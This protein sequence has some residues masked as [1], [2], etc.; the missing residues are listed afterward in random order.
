MRASLFLASIVTLSA[1]GCGDD[2]TSGSGGVG[3][4]SSGGSGGT[5]TTGGSGGVAS[6][7]DI[8]CADTEFCHAG[9]CRA[10]DAPTGTLHDRTLELGDDV[11][12]RHYFLHVPAGYACGKGTALL[13]DFHGTATGNRA[14][15]AYQLDALI[16]LSEAHDVIV[17][18]P[19]S[20]SSMEGGVETFRWDQ[21]PGDLERNVVFT[22]RLV[23]DL[24][25]RYD[26]DPL[27]IYATGFSSG[28]NM[29]S[30]FLATD[31]RGL[32]SGLA[33]IAGGIWADVN[34]EP[35]DAGEAPRFY[36]ATGFRDYLHASK[37]VLEEKLA[38]LGVPAEKVFVPGYDTGHDLYAWH[39]EELWAFLDTGTRP[40]AGSVTAP[41]QEEVL[42]DGV[43]I[44]EATRLPDGRI[45]A[46]G[47]RGDVLVRSV[48]GVWSKLTALS[49]AAPGPITGI[50]AD[51]TGAI[52]AVGEQAF[53]ASDAALTFGA[54]TTV[55]EFFGQFFG[56]AYLN[57][58]GCDASGAVV[59]AGYWSGAKS[60]DAGATWG[61][62][63]ADNLG[64]PGQLSAM[65]VTSQGTAIGVG[66]YDYIGRGAVTGTAL[67]YVDH[68]ATSEW[69]NGIGSSGNDVWVVGDG[70]HIVHSTDDGASFLEESSGSSA[71]LYAV[72]AADALMA[73]AVGREGTVVYT[74]DGGATWKSLSTGT[75]GYLGAVV[76]EDANT[77]LGLG[78]RALRATLPLN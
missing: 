14:E 69:W 45:A 12:D 46:T 27:R 50:C 74:R 48:A 5:I 61:G 66:Y 9:S 6:C 67:A 29:T 21:N 20:R 24:R 58:V 71:D 34:A 78:A 1:L 38:E 51:A 62:F 4:S 53:Y 37:Y 49:L 2:G 36:L 59:A 22:Q 60:V 32:F 42:P 11:D 64:F 70:G 41:W 75:S 72:A 40:A 44:V 55:P 28:S 25:S 8:T 52:R 47:S 13:V 15:E 35:F 68:G 73:V 33:P 19:R 10:C 56:E 76:F 23:E 54:G 26:I 31:A 63:E 65:H 16:A 30:Q 77:I 43:E 17:V 57:G 3:G 7:E 39:Y 18:R